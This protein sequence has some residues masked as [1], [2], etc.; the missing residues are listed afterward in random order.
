[1]SIPKVKKA[2]NFRADLFETLKE[3][4][5][6]EKHLVTHNSGDPVVLISQKEYNSLLD[7]FDLLKEISLG[8]HELDSGKWVSHDDAL[9]QI[10]SMKNKWK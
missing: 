10:E 8:A 3:V 4:S 6:G 1:M 9:K 2:S 7:K 5:N